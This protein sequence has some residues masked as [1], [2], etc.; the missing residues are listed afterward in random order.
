MARLID[1]PDHAL[2]VAHTLEGE[3][4]LRL[5]ARRV[6]V[7]RAHAQEPLEE[8][9]PAR[10]VLHP[11]DARLVDVAAEDPA[12]DDQA[13]VGDH[14]VGRDPPEPAHQEEDHKRAN[15]G[16]RDPCGLDLVL[17]ELRESRG[18][19]G[20]NQHGEPAK[21]VEMEDRAPGRVAL[22]DHVLALLKIHGFPH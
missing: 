5:V 13:A 15:R 2:R 3:R 16:D 22:V 11:V 21:D 6:E 8:G 17:D 18:G 12:P 7:D 9:L 14:V 10:H 4:V 20:D 19:G 1:L